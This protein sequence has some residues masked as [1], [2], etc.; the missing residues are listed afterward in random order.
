MDLNKK[1][2]EYFKK[3]VLFYLKKLNLVDWDVRIT[4]RK[5]IDGKGNGF[6]R[7]EFWNGIAEIS[8]I[9]KNYQL[10]KDNLYEDLDETARHECCHLILSKLE[11]MARAR[12][13]GE[14]E[15]TDTIEETIRKICNLLA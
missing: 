2:F 3:R 15:F 9:T 4:M 1:H 5:E 10:C 6:C 7:S 13:V 8:L 12:Y 11:T 14:R